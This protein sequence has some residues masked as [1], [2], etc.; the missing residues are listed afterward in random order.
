MMADG[1][2]NNVFVYMGG[3]QV[4]PP[5][6]T[7]AI[8]DRSVDTIRRRAFYNCRHLVSIVMHDGVKI[9]EEEALYG[10]ESLK[11]IKLPGVKVIEGEAFS[12]CTALE[13]V[14]FGDKLEAIE[15]QAFF[16]C[17]SLENIEFIGVKL[18]S[19]EPGVFAYCAALRNIN[20]RGVEHIKQH[21]FDNCTALEEVEFGEKLK[22]IDNQAF[23]RCSLRK[24]KL[25][26]VLI[27]QDYAF[28]ECRQLTDVE[29]S[30]DL[31]AIGGGSGY[32]GTFENCRSL[33]RIAI[34]LKDDL[35]NGPGA[36]CGCDN[37]SKVDLVG[38]IHKVIAS[39]HLESWR[40]EMNSEIDRINRD[41]PKLGAEDFEIPNNKTAAIEDWLVRILQRIE[42]YT[43]EHYALLKEAITLLELAIW[44]ANLIKSVED[45]GYP[46]EEKQP[47]KR[48][49]IDVDSTRQAARVTCGADIII[50]TVMP[51]LNNNDVFSSF[52]NRGEDAYDDDYE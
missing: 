50:K 12:D 38:G 29:L 37:L 48:A 20:L 30:E 34:P 23:R 5:R 49:K 4:V 40:N 1:G 22:F 3:D 17:N 39:L 52:L 10:C 9:I 47:V 25:P 46:P 42:H 31:E 44:K 21:A 24:I 13:D 14:E 15:Y 45:D 16:G 51:F 41:L 18:E 36:F 2:G 35:L 6:V 11:S 28:S 32:G 33:R 27:I 19:I 26:K 8:V 43:S 7:Y